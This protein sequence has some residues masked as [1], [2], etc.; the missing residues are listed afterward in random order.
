MKN[1]Y[2]SLLHLL[3]LYKYKSCEDKIY[4]FILTCDMPLHTKRVGLDYYFINKQ[5]SLREVGKI[6]NVTPERIRQIVSKFVRTLMHPSRM[7]YLKAQLDEEYG[8]LIAERDNLEKRLNAINM[9][10]RGYSSLEK[11]ISGNSPIDRLEFSV[12]TAK[13]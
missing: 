8:K 10:L 2:L 7:E 5:Y 1:N 11:D 6:Y 12:R 9:E 4:K 3:D 13:F